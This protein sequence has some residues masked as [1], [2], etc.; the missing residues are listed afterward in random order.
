[1]IHVEGFGGGYLD[2]DVEATGAAVRRADAAAFDSA[3]CTLECD[4]DAWHRLATGEITG[5]K[6]FM[7]GGFRL[8]GNSG[9]ASPGRLLRLSPCGPGAVH[10]R[11]PPMAWSASGAAGR[12]MRSTL[13][14]PRSSRRAP[15]CRR[16]P[17]T[18]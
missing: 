8:A 14:S 18:P 17:A 12:T 4:C 11:P 16:R 5:M 6:Q 2:V 1:M 10:D 9:L 15:G 3:E 7:D 13:G